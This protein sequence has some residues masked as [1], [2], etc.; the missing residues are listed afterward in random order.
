MFAHIVAMQLKPKTRQ[1]FTQTFENQIVP[2]L[3]KQQGFTG[4][5][6]DPVMLWTQGE[7]C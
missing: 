5:I 4:S 3:R 1:E 6:L 7:A 2:I